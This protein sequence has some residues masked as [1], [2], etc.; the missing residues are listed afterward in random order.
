M[1]INV[2]SRPRARP[3]GQVRAGARRVTTPAGLGGIE[4]TGG[5]VNAEDF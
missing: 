5:G 1:T 4:K 2:K 3:G